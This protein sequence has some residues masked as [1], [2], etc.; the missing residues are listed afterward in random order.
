MEKLVENPF[1]PVNKTDKLFIGSAAKD[2]VYELL[3]LG[4]N[5]ILINGKS[6][7]KVPLCGHID[8]MVSHYGNNLFFI[9]KFQIKAFNELSKLGITV[10]KINDVI[11]E[12]YPNDVK[13]NCVRINKSLICNIKSVSKNIIEK[14]MLDGLNIINVK[15]GYTKC[16]LLIANQNAVITDDE[17]VYSAMKHNYFD[18]LLVKKGSIDLPGY[19]Y[20]FIGGCGGLISKNE[21][22][23]FG[24]IKK[25]DSYNNIKSF[26]NNYKIHITSLSNKKLLDVGSI[27]PITE[28]EDKL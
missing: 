12:N 10:I 27:I 5:P 26:L 1:L 13:L 15:Q 21:M 11:S 18:V 16:S 2:F 24:D 8:M 9:D 22:V 6:A 19:S 4:V 20:G 23:F 25:H 3:G 17:T 14:A 7:L 28:C